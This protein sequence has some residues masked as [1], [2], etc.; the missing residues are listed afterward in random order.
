[1]PPRP[2]RPQVRKHEGLALPVQKSCVSVDLDQ[3]GDFCRKLQKQL[4]FGDVDCRNNEELFARAFFF[5]WDLFKVAASDSKEW[6]LVLNTAVTA[7]SE[8]S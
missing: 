2:Y 3:L 8:L 1:M 5:A 4:G 7:I 6:L